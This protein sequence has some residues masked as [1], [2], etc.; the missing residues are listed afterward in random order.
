MA[1]RPS[2]SKCVNR[3]RN[4]NDHTM[5]VAAL[6][7]RPGSDPNARPPSGAGRCH[8][9]LAPHARARAHVASFIVASVAVLLSPDAAGPGASTL[10]GV[11]IPESPVI[12]RP[13]MYQDW[14]DLTF[15]HWR[16]PVEAVQRLLPT[17]LA[18]Q[19][20]DGSAWVGLVP[21]VMDRVRAPATPPVPW[22]SR[23]P[24]TNVRTYVTGPGGAEGIYFFSLD[25]ARLPAVVTGRWTYALPYLWSRM[26]VAASAGE[27]RYASVR[28]WPGPRG[29]RCDAVVSRG[30]PVAPGPLEYFLTYRFRLYSTVRRR[31]VCAGAAHGPWPL[32]SGSVVSL[33][34]SVLAA[35]GLPGPRGEPLVH[36]SPGVS[37][38]IGGWRRVPVD[39]SEV[40]G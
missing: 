1:N 4:Y 20:F 5:F 14:R 17:D 35:A 13:V 7:A 25:A 40:A 8:L 29:A 16:Y 33:D 11:A 28:R 2:H 3:C 31:L 32:F 30:T 19:T 15:L 10:G 36:T 6:V 24:E 26:S 27:F 12:P 34:E 37:V 21:F 22:L 39:A 18:A 23:F 38:R 9:A